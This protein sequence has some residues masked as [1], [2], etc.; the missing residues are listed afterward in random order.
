MLAA[1]A[2]VGETVICNAARE[3]EILDLQCYL[4]KLGADISGA[5]TSTVTVSGFRAFPR[6][7]SR[8]S[9]PPA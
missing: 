7:R 3:P 8:R 4:R 9:W 2:A 6:M 5:G 1:C